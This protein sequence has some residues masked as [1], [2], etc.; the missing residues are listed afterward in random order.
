MLGIPQLVATSPQFLPP[1]PHDHLHLVWIS[2]SLKLPL[3]L[4]DLEHQALDLG[5]TLIKYDFT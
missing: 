2:V 4:L 5:S 3:Q 1:F